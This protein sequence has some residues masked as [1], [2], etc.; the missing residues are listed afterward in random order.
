MLKSA[1]DEL[2][3]ARSTLPYMVFQG[4][5]AEV[6][7]RVGQVEQGVALI[8]KAIEQCERRE[9]R[10]SLPELIRIKGQLLL[11]DNAAS[12]SP[13][14]PS[15]RDF[16]FGVRGVSRSPLPALNSPMPRKVLAEPRISPQ[17]APL[18]RLGSMSDLSP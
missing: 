18:F 13:G 6:L 2:A 7:G 8:E 1:L 9:E 15:G 3:E 4:E 11:L 10:W 5:L 14:T 16:P 12:V 17:S